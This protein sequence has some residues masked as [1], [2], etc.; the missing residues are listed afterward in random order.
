MPHFTID[1]FIMEE[2]ILNRKDK[3]KYSAPEIT[4][5]KIDKEI[6]LIMMSSNP[7]DNPPEESMPDNFNLNPFKILKL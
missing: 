7:G 3:R 5:I 4:E 1:P 2:D 6:S